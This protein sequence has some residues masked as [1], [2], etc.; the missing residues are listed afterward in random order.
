MTRH[1]ALLASVIV[2]I[3]LA[4]PSALEAQAQR[5]GGSSSGSSSSGGSQGGGSVA[6]PRSA[7]APAPAPAVR[8]RPSQPSGDSGRAAR[9]AGSRVGSS[10]ARGGDS[11]PGVS[12]G[13]RARSNQAIR[14]QAQPRTGA[15]PLPRPSGNVRLPWY[16]WGYNYGYNYGYGYG[17][18]YGYVY[19]PWLYGGY[20][21]DPFLYGPFAYG[22][23]PYYWGGGTISGRDDAAVR[24][25]LATGSI[26]LRV[27]PGQARVYIDGALAG[28]ASEFG[29]LTDHLILPEG[30]HELELRADGY[31]TYTGQIDVREGRTRTERV[32][33][34][35]Q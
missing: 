10:G 24:D 32:N 8:E 16:G 14:G 4:A 29:G 19:D 9:P 31:Q 35:K 23:R 5:R 11:A 6:V 21:G 1:S 20:W 25:E 12:S 28:V 3:A 34:K 7:P 22:G 13:P 33:M 2:A 30:R 17:Y 26:R 18:P 15:T 27:N